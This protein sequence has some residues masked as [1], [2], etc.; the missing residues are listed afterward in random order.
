MMLKQ[1]TADIIPF[2]TE[3]WYIVAAVLMI[4]IIAIITLAILLS[5]AMRNLKENSEVTKARKKDLIQKQK[6][7]EE[8]ALQLK[9]E[10][11][12]KETNAPQTESQPQQGENV[13]QTDTAQQSED[14][15][16]AQ[17]E[18][19][20]ADATADLP[21]NNNQKEIK[22]AETTEKKAVYRVI[23]DKD[24]KEW[25][26]KKDGATRVIRRVRTKAEALELANQFAENQ[27]LSLS[28][29]KKD[30]KFQKKSNY[31]QMISDKGEKKE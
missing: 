22:M 3:Y 15:L 14:N 27:D 25:L 23:Y 30:G 11:E 29:Q 1:L 31:M 4:A 17:T 26:I 2:L 8:K 21:Q 5:R 19:A 9:L 12:A 7:E 18:V 6:K 13:S 24:N 16:T 10:R 28:V 20:T